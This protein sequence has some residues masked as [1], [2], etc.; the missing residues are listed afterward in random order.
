MPVV[1]DRRAHVV[2]VGA[3]VPERRLTNADLMGMV[4]T[5]DEW[6][7]SRTGV[8][9]RRVVEPGTPVSVLAEA[10]ARRCLEQAGVSASELDGI[11]IAT[12]TPDQMMPSTANIVQHRLGATQAWGF[13]LLNACNG[14][15]TALATATSY[16][17]AGRARRILVI[18]ADVM[19]SIVD[20]TDRNTCILFGDGA[21][22][23][24]VVAGEADARGVGP[25]R[26][27]SDGSGANELRLPASGSLPAAEG[28]R[29][30]L[31]QNGK[32]VF[33]HAVRRMAEVAEAVL[34]QAGGTPVD[35]L[36]PHQANLRIIQATAE[37]CRVPMERVVVNIDRLGNT[38]AATLPLALA[39]AH[40]DG[41]LKAG[42]SVLLVAFGGGFTWGALHLVWG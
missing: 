18:G 42:T 30:V 37:R 1:S 10:A 38:T 41:R 8:R 4:E 14:F 27:H 21:G 11:I 32:T 13:D 7:I 3:C 16:I 12:I 24:L 34:A 9:E 40:A 20:Y 15:L 23:V 31:R 22:A 36:V 19:S 25:F 35:L 2:A 29:R 6:I 26:M 39:D 17:E 33:Q 5:T 28:E